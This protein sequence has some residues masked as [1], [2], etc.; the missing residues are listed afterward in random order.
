MY[1]AH[2]YNARTAIIATRKRNHML[3]M[4]KLASLHV[5]TVSPQCAVCMKT[6]HMNM[7]NGV[8]KQYFCC[9]PYV[10]A[11]V[12]FTPV[13]QCSAHLRVSW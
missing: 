8:R 3:H 6:V 5:I 7:I 4:C 11:Q 9:L 1:T 13:R 12:A 10:Q 2:T